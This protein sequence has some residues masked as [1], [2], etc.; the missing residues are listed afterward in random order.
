MR[1]PFFRLGLISILA[2]AL[3]KQLGKLG[4]GLTYQV[5]IIFLAA[6]LFSISH[7]LLPNGDLFTPYSFVYRIFFALLMN[8]LLFFRRF[9]ITAWTHAW[10]D[11]IYFTFA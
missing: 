8:T 7:Y 2:F 5:L 11:M 10:Y 1:K 3:K 4:G 9:A 6:V